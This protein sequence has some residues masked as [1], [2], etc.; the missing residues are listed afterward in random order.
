MLYRSRLYNF[1][2][3]ITRFDFRRGFTTLSQAIKPQHT[4][5]VCEDFSDKRKAVKAALNRNHN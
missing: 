2:I 3:K 4:K 5:S 1:I